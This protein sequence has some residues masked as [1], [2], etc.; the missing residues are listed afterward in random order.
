MHRW[1]AR[2]WLRVVQ[3]RALRLL[4]A[5]GGGVRLARPARALLRT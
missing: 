5:F 4:A 2:L 3:S 1:Y